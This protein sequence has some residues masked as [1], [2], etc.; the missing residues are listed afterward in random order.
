[1]FNYI[2]EKYSHVIDKKIYTEIVINFFDSLN[3][4]D[5]K[6]KYLNGEYHF[7]EEEFIEKRCIDAFGPVGI[8]FVEIDS[9]IDLND[10]IRKNEDWKKFNHNACLHLTK[11]NELY[12]L[13]KDDEFNYIKYLMKILCINESEAID[14]VIIEIKKHFETILEIKELLKKSLS[15]LQMKHLDKMIRVCEG[16]LYWSN[17]CDRYNK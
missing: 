12:S 8:L 2:F 10:P 9:N 4:L 11:V 14:L 5:L 15:A 13:K 3:V 7:K 17:M 16:N 1:M 6:N